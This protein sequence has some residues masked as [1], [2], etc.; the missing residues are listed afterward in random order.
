MKNFLYNLEI[1]R[2]SIFYE[3]FLKLFSKVIILWF[4]FAIFEGVGIS[5]FYPIIEILQFGEIKQDNHLTKSLLYIFSLFEVSVTLPFIF[6]LTFLLLTIRFLLQYLKQKTISRAV[7]QVEF[8]IRDKLINSLYNSNLSFFIK[9]KEGEWLSSFSYDVVR[10]RNV[11]AD[12]GDLLGNI[13]LIFIYIIILCLISFELFIYC[14]PIF[15]IGALI[16]KTRSKYF[17]KVGKNISKNTADYLTTHEDAMKNIIFLK[18]KNLISFFEKKLQS[19]S[20]KI[21]LLQYS[22]TKQNFKIESIFGFILLVGVFYVLIISK[23]FLSLDL[24]QIAIF[25]FIL[26][27]ISPC[28]Q[29]SLKSLLN[30]LVNIQSLRVIIELAKKADKK[31]EENYGEE[32]IEEN[33]SSIEFKN[34]NFSYSNLRNQKNLVD[35]NFKINRGKSIGLIG[36]SGSGKSTLLNILTGFYKHNSGHLFINN[37]K[38]KQLDVNH[39]RKKI[40]YIP[41]SPELFNDTILNNLIIGIDREI[42]K[43]MILKILKDCYCDFIFNLPKKLDNIVGDRGMLLSGGQRQRLVIARAI[44]NKSELIILDE[45]TNGLDENSEMKIKK[46]LQRFKKNTIQI[47]CSHRIST[48]ENTDK[49]LYLNNGK[50]VFFGDTKI[51]LNKEVI[52]K[53]FRGK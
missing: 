6:A 16:L 53:F 22:V 50:L 34:L 9:K 40:S 12:I 10:A 8:K 33:I 39:F 46:T 5:L 14:T 37:K 43:K 30:F 7:H 13:F 36:E 47:I 4:S 44:L 31:K 11:I 42:D 23:F 52:R 27:R 28:L 18:M 26:N 38:I 32:I 41:Q 15:F 45:A 35:I 49:L 1:F 20:K 24:F 2:N 29:N 51:N 17:E 25:L 19:Q 3:E 21:A 48:I